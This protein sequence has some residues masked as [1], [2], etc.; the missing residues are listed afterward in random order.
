ML[1]GHQLASRCPDWG[2]PKREF[3]EP[4]QYD[5]RVQEG[6][7]KINL[8]RFSEICVFLRASRLARAT[9]AK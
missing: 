7:R 9:V 1:T 3:T 8:F 2:A 5:R 6:V 4:L